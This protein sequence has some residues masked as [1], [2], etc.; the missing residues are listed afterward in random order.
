MNESL[1]VLLQQR[2]EGEDWTAFQKRIHPDCATCQSPETFKPSHDGSR[3]CESGSL[4]SGGHR[5]HCTCDT[6]F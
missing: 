6:C 2:L 3:L 1:D 5:R 4:A